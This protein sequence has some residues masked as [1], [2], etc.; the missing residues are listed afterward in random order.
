MLCCTEA[1]GMGPASV[2][3]VDR[4]PSEPDRERWPTPPEFRRNWFDLVYAF[5]ACS[6]QTCRRFLWFGPAHL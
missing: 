5:L 4:L 1:C 3:R 2:W 6:S